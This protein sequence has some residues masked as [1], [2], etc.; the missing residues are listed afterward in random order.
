M[1]VKSSE[2]E[3]IV[4]LTS[5][6]REE[7]LEKYMGKGYRSACYVSPGKGLPGCIKLFGFDKDGNRTTFVCPHKCRIKYRVGY[8]TGEKDIFGNFVQTKT[9]E[10]PF[11]RKRWIEDNPSVFIVQSMKPEQEFL[12]DLFKEVVLDSDFNQQPMRIFYIDIETEMGDQFEGPTTAAQRINMITVYDTGTGKYHTWSLYD[13]PKNLFKEDSDLYVLHTFRNSEPLMLQWF[14]DWWHDNMPDVVCGWNSEAFDIPYII[15]RI[16]NVFGE[17]ELGKKLCQR[18]SPVNKYSKKINER[19]ISKNERANVSAEMTV[20]INGLF[21]ADA[22]RLYRDKFKIHDALDGGYGL[23]NVGDAEGLGKKLDYSDEGKG[24]LRDLY[25]KN[26]QM[27][28]E[29]NVRDVELLKNIEQKTKLIALAR[30]VTSI[31][32]SDYGT[33]YGSASYLLQ[34][35]AIFAATKMPEPAVFQTYMKEDFNKIPYEGAFVFD[36]VLGLFTGGVADIDFNSLYPS[37]IRSLNL[38]PETFVG[39]IESIEEVE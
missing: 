8:D 15:R 12:F 14:V 2:P 29:Y 34:S 16:E 18:L 9:F 27:F 39:K 3:S 24:T 10:S 30:R 38:S 37:T 28:Y 26:R 21:L 22:L 25:M 13:E 35:L 31:G 5:V 32:L 1:Y 17:E 33:V 7:W 36:P 23:T 19:D 20:T 4:D 6:P 11:D